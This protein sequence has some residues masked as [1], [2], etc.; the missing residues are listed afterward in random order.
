MGRH[1][2]GLAL[3]LQRQHAPSGISFRIRRR[4][5]R[6]RIVGDGGIARLPRFVGDGMLL[7]VTDALLF[8]G[9]IMSKLLTID[10][11]SEYQ[12]I[13]DRWA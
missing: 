3:A 6:G 8:F 1:P 9:R 10:E 11:A 4:R 7:T 5:P 13:E 12:G 2:D